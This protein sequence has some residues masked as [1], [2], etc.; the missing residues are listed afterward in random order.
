MPT[1]YIEITPND[2]MKVSLAAV[3]ESFIE[4]YNGVFKDVIL[5]KTDVTKLTHVDIANFF[6]V[7]ASMVC[8]PK[9]IEPAV[10]GMLG[11]NKDLV[12]ES[13]R[14]LLSAKGVKQRIPFL[15]L[16]TPLC[17]PLNV[18]PTDKKWVDWFGESYV[19]PVDK[20]EA[21]YTDSVYLIDTRD[22]KL[23]LAIEFKE[24]IPIEDNPVNQEVRLQDVTFCSKEE[25]NQEHFNKEIARIYNTI[26]NPT[27][28]P[29]VNWL[30]SMI[31][32]VSQ[33]DNHLWLSKRHPY[34]TMIP[35]E[36]DLEVSLRQTLAQTRKVFLA[37]MRNWANDNAK[38]MVEFFIDSGRWD[39][40]DLAKQYIS[41]HAI[42]NVILY[43]FRSTAT[44]V[45]YLEAVTVDGI[46]SNMR[47]IVV[48]EA[49][50]DMEVIS[51]YG[52]VAEGL[53]RLAFGF[54]VEADEKLRVMLAAVKDEWVTT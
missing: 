21:G 10:L 53:L 15:S 24:G 54:G 22:N 36:N 45:P 8:L 6:R 33:R 9:S 19:L 43:V 38:V 28:F 12:N 41:Y 4:I 40:S 31:N 1:K 34:P 14:C 23:T 44:T 25:A 29:G 18:D 35:E 16:H 47:T 5:S 27:P 26:E 46:I 39:L 49:G 30:L 20:R 17:I 32:A 13:L 42:A 7:R 50:N 3:I 52:D 51:L 37:R 11:F 48:R 2:Q